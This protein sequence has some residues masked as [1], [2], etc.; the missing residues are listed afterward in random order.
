MNIIFTYGFQECKAENENPTQLWGVF[1]FGLHDLSNRRLD[2]AAGKFQYGLDVIGEGI[3]YF[4]TIVTGCP[5]RENVRTL[6]KMVPL[7]LEMRLLGGGPVIW[8]REES[9]QYSGIF[10]LKMT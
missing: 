5:F 1:S 2:I 7:K 3:P 9:N 6:S 10:S 8:V 4:D